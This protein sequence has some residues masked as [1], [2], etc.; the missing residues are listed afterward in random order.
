MGLGGSQGQARS[1]VALGRGCPGRPPQE[2]W[3]RKK[4][5]LGA[6]ASQSLLIALRDQAPH[7][8][9]N[10]VDQHLAPSFDAGR[11]SHTAVGSCVTSLAPFII[12]LHRAHA[13]DPLV[14]GLLAYPELEAP[15]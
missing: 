6:S 4:A 12:R 1:V 14:M 13:H 7:D 5:R 10:T 2:G 9:G 11:I 3:L 15:D 8:G